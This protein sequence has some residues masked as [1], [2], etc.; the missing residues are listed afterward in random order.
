MK[1]I[2]AV[3]VLGLFLSGNAYADDIRDF[4]IEGM[5]LGDSALKYYSENEIKTNKQ[6]WY[7]SK[8]YSTKLVF[9]F[10]NPNGQ[11]FCIREAINF[12]YD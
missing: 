2:L 4:Q 8:K 9:F 7:K 3:I 5:S 12:F 11:R 6:N 1:K 10:I